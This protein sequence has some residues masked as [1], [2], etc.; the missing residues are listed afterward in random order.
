[1]FASHNILQRAALVALTSGALWT[2]NSP[3][4]QATGTTQAQAQAQTGQGQTNTGAT[5]R[6]ISNP[7]TDSLGLSFANNSLTISS[8]ADSSPLSGIGLQAGDRILSVNGHPAGS[9]MNLLN[10]LSRLAGGNGGASI[11]VMNA[12]GAQQ[13]LNVPVSALQ[14]I[15]QARLT[16]PG[17]G[18]VPADQLRMAQQNMIA[19][20]L[21]LSLQTTP[22]GML[23]TGIADNSPLQGL[24]LQVGDQIT[25]LNNQAIGNPTDLLN[26][27]ALAAQNQTRDGT[28]LD[29]IRNGDRV[30][31][32]VPTATLQ[33]VAQAR[34]QSGVGAT[35]RP[36][37][38]TKSTA[39]PTNT[40]A[41]TAQ[42]TGTTAASGG[43]PLNPLVQQALNAQ[44]AANQG[45]GNNAA[46]SLNSSSG[47]RTLHNAAANSPGGNTTGIPAQ[48]TGTTTGSGG[49]ATNPLVQQALDTQAAANESNTSGVQSLKMSAANTAGANNTTPDQQAAVN[50]LSGFQPPA[51]GTTQSNGLP[52]TVI[53]PNGP[54]IMMPG[55]QGQGQGG[56]GG[57][58]G[59]LPAN[60]KGVPGGG[61]AEGK[62][63]GAHPNGGAHGGGA[64]SGGGAAAVKVGAS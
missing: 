7:A 63:G 44:A 27:L 26:R 51:S 23:V 38:V 30:T 36:G 58:A 42:P 19:Q 45:S 61:K 1:M 3:A 12:S 8:I 10:D 25:G 35:A 53:T 62:A 39:T 34:A 33:A 47:L 46:A 48:P 14:S 21:G 9:A 6:S 31:V 17:R 54:K 64:R 20:S 55:Q 52:T 16:G 11:T 28:N 2:A 41:A 13:T 32:P 4:Q 59:S 22:N 15:V 40:A 60:A 43:V 56:G 57:G 50:A 18:T 24:G 29:L 37:L 49:T 5:A